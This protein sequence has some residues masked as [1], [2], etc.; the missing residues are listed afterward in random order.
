MSHASVTK[1]IE[2]LLFSRKFITASALLLSDRTFQF[3][4]F[5]TEITLPEID[6]VSFFDCS[7]R[8]NF[9]ACLSL[10]GMMGRFCLVQSGCA[11]ENL[12]TFGS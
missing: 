7:M 10:I 12:M 9:K 2:M 4:H 1:K 8:W 6:L 3:A 11:V 5:I